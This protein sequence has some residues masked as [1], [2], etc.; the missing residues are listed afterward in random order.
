MLDAVMRILDKI[1]M[2]GDLFYLNGIYIV[3]FNTGMAEIMQ[4]RRDVVIK[5]R[6]RKGEKILNFRNVIGR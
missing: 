1:G 4:D 3:Y 6:T 5:I 2:N